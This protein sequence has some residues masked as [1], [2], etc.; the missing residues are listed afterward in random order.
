[1]HGREYRVIKI[2]NNKAKRVGLL[3]AKVIPTL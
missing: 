2:Q 3:T 1:V